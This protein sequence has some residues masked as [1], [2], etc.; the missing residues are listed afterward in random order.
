[1]DCC[2][3]FSCFQ[4]ITVPRN[5]APPNQMKYE[6]GEMNK[7]VMCDNKKNNMLLHT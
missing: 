5:W 7:E 4:S 6:E 2:A 3:L 1:M